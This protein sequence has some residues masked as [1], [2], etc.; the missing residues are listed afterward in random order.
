MKMTVNNELFS[1]KDRRNALM[2]SSWFGV[3][4]FIGF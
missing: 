1:V 4:E 2:D 3:G